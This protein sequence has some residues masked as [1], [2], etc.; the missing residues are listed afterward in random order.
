MCNCERRHAAPPMSETSS[1]PEWYRH[2]PLAAATHAIRSVPHE[3]RVIPAGPVHLINV[4]PPAG[5]VVEAP[6]PEYALNLLLDTAP[7]L[8]VGFNRPPRWLAVSPGAML[9]TPPDTSCEFIGEASAHVLAVAIPKAHVDAVAQDTG[10]RIDLREEAAFRDPRLVRQLVGLWHE[11][12]A[13]TQ[14]RRLLADHVT[15]SVIEA[16]ATRSGSAARL[17]ARAARERL[18]HRTLRRLRDY[19]E[20]SLA[21]DLDVTV[22][23]Q[24]AGTSPAHFARA[25]AATVGMTPFR[26]VMTRRLAR[27]RELLER[28]RR[29]AQA[30]AVEVGFKTP[31]HFASRFRREFGVA[32]TEIRSFRTVRASAAG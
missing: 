13:D 11:L 4:S 6:V 18:T 16:L 12:S 22:M 9:F 31:S 20:H 17:S 25:F 3:T 2:G 21:D 32:P 7:L 14:D 24:V 29:P 27:A 26:Y 8:R 23:A 10:T 28:S 30:V 5:Q 15:R 19:V 1:A